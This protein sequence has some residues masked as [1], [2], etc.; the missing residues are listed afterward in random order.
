MARRTGPQEHWPGAVELAARFLGRGWEIG[1]AVTRATDL[2][3][4]RDPR[5]SCGCGLRLGEEDVRQMGPHGIQQMDSR[6]RERLA[7]RAPHAVNGEAGAHEGPIRGT[8]LSAPNPQRGPRG[9]EK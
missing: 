2:V 9:R 5:R 4:A 1:D 8:H 7:K 6:E 3:Y